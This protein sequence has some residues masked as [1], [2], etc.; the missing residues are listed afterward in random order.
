MRRRRVLGFVGAAI[1]PFS[2]C[3]E[4]G[5]AVADETETPRPTH[6]PTGTTTEPPPQRLAFGGTA[7]FAD[8]TTLTV[9]D[10]T[11]QKSIIA[12]ADAFLLVERYAGHQFVVVSVQGSAAV[13][14]SDF[15]VRRD[16][17]VEAPP[18]QRSCVEPVTRDC[19]A[20][21]I[22][23]PIVTGATDDA[24]VVYQPADRV[25]AAWDLPAETVGLFAVQPRCELREA[26]L[27]DRDGEVAVRFTVEN[28][29]AR[30]AGFRA[31]VAPEDIADVSDPAGFVVPEG[32]TVTETVVPLVLDGYSPEEVTFTRE[33]NEDTRVFTVGSR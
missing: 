8:G 22:G 30:D 20:T 28:V 10:P 33:I 9:V 13:E 24:A 7:T 25:R 6:S 29:G 4:G 12:D 23:L 15:A 11:V 3:S 2:G 19:S 16:G 5:Q 32:E 17:R 27:T 18:E 14:P 1:I 21:C 26:E 31:L